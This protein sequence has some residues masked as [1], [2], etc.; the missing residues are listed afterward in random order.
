VACA[1]VLITCEPGCEKVIYDELR[2]TPSIQEVNVVYGLCDIV[3]KIESEKFKNVLSNIRKIDK[4]R[5]TLTLVV[6]EGQ[7]GKKTE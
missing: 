3:A 2:K 1:Y 6:V 5:S 4:V 7:K